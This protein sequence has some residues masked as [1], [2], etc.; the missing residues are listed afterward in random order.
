MTAITGM[1]ITATLKNGLVVTIREL[2]IEDRDAIARAVA[3]LEAETIYTRLLGYRRMTATDIDRIMHVDPTHEMAFVAVIGTPP[4]HQIIGSC[5]FVELKTEKGR[6]AAEV[7][8]MV[9]EDYQGLG[10]AGR[11]LDHL[12][13]IA[14]LRGIAEFEGDVL[15]SNQSM[16][17]V[18]QRSG[19]PTSIRHD[20]ANLHLTLSLT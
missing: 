15:A 12:V 20:G 6:R 3:G 13:H 2:R 16:L 17:R 10:I 4:T 18:I 5:R 7:A 9:E 19:L 8:F 14:R 1:E 11:L